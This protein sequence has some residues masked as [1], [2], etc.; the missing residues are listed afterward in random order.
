MK[1]KIRKTW[2]WRTARKV[3]KYFVGW[4][5]EKYNGLSLTPEIQNKIQ[6][7]IK[8]TRSIYFHDEKT[9][10]NLANNWVPQ[11]E[12]QAEDLRFIENAIPIVLCF[13]DDFAPYTA[14]MLQS[15]LDNSNPQRKYHFIL[16]EQNISDTT[17]KYLCNQISCFSHC[18][19]DFVNT[20]DAINKIP[21]ALSKKTHFSSDI[22]SRFFIPYWLD[23]YSKVIYC[24]SDMIAMADIAELY[25][26]D[27]QGHCM[28][29]T[30]NQGVS[31][32]L[33]H[34]NYSSAIFN[35][36]PAAFLFLEN[37]FRYINSGLLVFDI[38][39]FKKKISYENLFRFCIYYTNR[40]KKIFGDQDVLSLLVK[41][42]YFLLPREW[43]Y[44]WA[45]FFFQPAE[46]NTKMIHFTSKIKPWKNF[47]EIANNPD[48]LAYR[49]YA[50]NVPLY[51]MTHG[52]QNNKK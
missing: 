17:K 22:F 15:L 18:S 3:K 37:W 47:P 41:D 23:G 12:A 11:S 10:K 36:S 28:A 21:F 19:I 5:I 40:Y 30:V 2:F 1:L 50:K 27:I 43:N 9:A 51:N 31:S 34:K 24:D 39:R 26:L 6:C 16:F 49:D 7:V 25:D 46:P 4:K 44:C 42:D 52:A 13:N 20:K 45:S 8:R 29:A 33:Q 32:A 14:V 35:S 48:A 38:E